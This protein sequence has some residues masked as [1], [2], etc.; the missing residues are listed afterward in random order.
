MTWP[1]RLNTP[2]TAGGASGTGVYS[3]Y[4][5]TS[6]TVCTSTP[7]S[8]PAT[9]KVANCRLAISGLHQDLV[10]LQ[11]GVEVRVGG[12]D[13]PAHVQQLGHPLLDDRGADQAVLL[14]VPAGRGRVLGDV[15]DPV[16]HQRHAPPALAVDDHRHGVALRLLAVR[17]EQVRQPYQ[18]KDLAAVLDHLAGAG[19][20][21]PGPRK[22][23]EPGDRVQRDR[24]PPLAH[25][26]DQQPLAGAGAGARPG[27]GLHVLPL[28]VGG[29]MT[30]PGQRGDVEDQADLA[31]AQDGRARVQADVLEPAVQGFDPDLFGVQH[32]VDDQAEPPAVGLQ[33]HD[34]DAL[35]AADVEA[36]RPVQPHEGQQ[37]AAQPVDGRARGVLNLGGISVDEH[38]LEYGDLGYDIS[39]FAAVDGQRLDDGQG[40]RDGEPPD[41]ALAGRRVD[42]HRAADVLDVGL[43]D[44]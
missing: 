6:W 34:V 29:Q 20:L 27:R 38:Q 44:V 18:R 30:A 25:R 24:H 11:V 13:G 9:S 10:V 23:L 4:E 40:Q 17:P 7:K 42:A 15:H 33:D 31:V 36:E 28:G 39:L 16:H 19:V 12:E 2:P 5:S 37:L 35:V 32:P 22:L 21:D 8:W 41:G 43:H 26:G 14:G 3:L 1:R